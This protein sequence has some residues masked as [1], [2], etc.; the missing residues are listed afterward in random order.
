MEGDLEAGE[1]RVLGLGIADDARDLVAVLEEQLR[2][3]GA[4]LTRRARDQ[5]LQCSP[6]TY[7]QAS[8]RPSERR[9]S[10]IAA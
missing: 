5:R 10:T 9:A 1:V 4:V 7:V 2:E 8:L 3:V 6:R